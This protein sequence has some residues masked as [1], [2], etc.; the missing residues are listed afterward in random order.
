M[1][2]DDLRYVLAIARA[3]TL[4]GAG[5]RLGVSHTTA[6]R[7]LR[8]LEDVLGVRLFDR[9]PDGLEATSS[10][11][12]LI[13]V[14]REMERQVLALEGRVAGR[15][16][17]LTGPLRV[18]TMDIF[19]MAFHA[20]IMAF[21]A[22]YPEVDLTVTSSNAELSLTR[23][24]ADVALRMSSTPPD[25]LIGRRV[26]HVRFAPYA[27]AAL[28]ERVGAD[29]PLS[30]YPWLRWDERM[31]L[32]HVES[33]LER[34]AP[35]ARVVLRTDFD[36]VLLREAVV[37]GVGV[38]VLSC[39]EGDAHPQLR[40]IGPILDGVGRDLWLLTLPDL[41]GSRR[42]RAFMDHMADAIHARRHELEGVIPDA[43]PAPRS[44]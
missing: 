36:S 42:V 37:A 5:E 13:E 6:G 32:D 44:G 23:R 25:A 28:V 27:S 1:D 15:D 2:W 3:R 40:R 16:A 29:A 21:A 35:G 18:T 14:A 19:F 34:L 9:T 10:G 39:V 43:A 12:D 8:A 7:R 31:G 33:L 22:R 4:V 24:E 26:G 30:A 11:L 38:H 20:E 17:R 41:K